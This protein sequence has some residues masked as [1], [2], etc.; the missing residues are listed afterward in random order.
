MPPLG[1]GVFSRYVW[2]RT[3]PCP[4]AGAVVPPSGPV[5][6]RRG[7]FRAQAVVPRA[8]APPYR[9]GYAQFGAMRAVEPDGVLTYTVHHVCSLHRAA[10]RPGYALL[11][12]AARSASPACLTSRSSAGP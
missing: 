1:V 11:A 9:R 10:R 5:G 3:V 2:M 12:D 8:Y 7:S 6:S 4:V